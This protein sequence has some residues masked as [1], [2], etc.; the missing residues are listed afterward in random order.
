MTRPDPTKLRYSFV[1]LHGMALLG[2]AVPVTLTLSRDRNAKLFS[3]GHDV[4]ELY[5]ALQ[6][7]VNLQAEEALPMLLS[8]PPFK[9]AKSSVTLL[10]P[11][12]VLQI[13][14]DMP[15]QVAVMHY[16][17][18]NGPLAVANDIGTA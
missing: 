16:R 10:Y 14:Q 7:V 11:E 15:Q 18:I 1:Q 17:I 6:Y 12:D 4:L 2:L 9:V 3:H 8:I 5:D 13:D